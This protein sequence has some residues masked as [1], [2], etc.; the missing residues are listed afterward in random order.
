MP[1][2]HQVIFWAVFLGS[3]SALASCGDEGEGKPDGGLDGDVLPDGETIE[4]STGDRDGSAPVEWE[5]P[6]HDLVWQNDPICRLTWSEAKAYCEDLDWAGHQDWR[7]PSI[8][9]LRTLIHGCPA[10]EPDGSCGVT[11]SCLGFGC[12]NDTCEDCLRDEGPTPGGMYWPS[13][14]EGECCWYWSSSGQ[15]EHEDYAWCVDFWSARIDAQWTEA[16]YCVRCV[17]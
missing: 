13:P 10:T 9:E 12:W 3:A 4:D 16:A 11:D 8:S 14:I 17:R 7:L 1:K 2:I 5:D 6:D 15:A